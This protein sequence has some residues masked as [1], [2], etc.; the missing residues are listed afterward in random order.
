MRDNFIKGMAM[1]NL[2]IFSLFI[3]S[4]VTWANEWS[5]DISLQSRSFNKDALSASQFKQYGSVAIKAE[6]FHDW[7]G[8][9]QSLTFVPFTRWDQ[10]D[11]ER[12]HSDIRELSWLKVFDESELRIGLRKVFWGVSE[13]QH[14][15]DVINQTDLVEGMDGEEKLGQPM[16]NYAMINDWGTVDFFILPYFRERTY[17]G[18]NGRLR[19]TLHIDTDNPIYEST[20]KE[21]HIDYAIRWSHSLGDWDI[22]LSHFD[23][24]SRDPSISTTPTLDNNGI[25]SLRPTYYLMQQTGIDVQATKEAWLWK[26]EMINRS[27][28]NDSYNAATAGFEYT[29]NGVFES[30][31]DLGIV[32]EYLYDDRASQA[33][34]PFEDDL[35]LGLRWTK[36]DENDTTLLLGVIADRDEST[37]IYS[38]EASRR[39]GESFKLN[40]EARLFKGVKTNDLFLG[41]LR[42][43]NF[44]QL[45]LAYYF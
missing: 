20:D 18:V 35:M 8:G 2:F 1:K 12:T 9:K 10:H 26:M 41:S 37:R 40:I 3:I 14:L 22:G 39:I 42:Q 28:N 19:P 15:V 38:V 25:L 34:T 24:T 16:I 45:E 32:F 30:S 27:I 29:V 33:T 13:S 36:N 17:P 43:D 23:G 6:W 31:S 5:G 4:S 7:D 21:N 11:D 44:V